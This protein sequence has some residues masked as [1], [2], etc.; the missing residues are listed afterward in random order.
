MG[1]YPYR[2]PDV[3]PENV[4]PVL[5]AL[6]TWV[7]GEL[8]EGWEIKLTMWGGVDY[9]GDCALSLIDPSGDDVSV[10]WDCD[11]RNIWDMVDHA[12]NVQVEADDASEVDDGAEDPAGA[13][14]PEA[15]VEGGAYPA[16]GQGWRHD[17]G[18]GGTR[19]SEVG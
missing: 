3:H 5:N 12:R 15:A 1:D 16:H 9:Q 10:D 11:R 6:L 4:R 17:P 13:A 2:P 14:P 18:A 8:P 7:C 19:H